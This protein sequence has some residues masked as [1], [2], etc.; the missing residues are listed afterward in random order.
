M[1]W[2]AGCASLLAVLLLA[3]G[4]A[5]VAQTDPLAGL[6][7]PE[8]AQH[9]AQLLA[10]TE[11]AFPGLRFVGRVEQA[12]WSDLAGQYSWEQYIREVRSGRGRGG[13]WGQSWWSTR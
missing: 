4:C 12:D 13:W 8:R 5:C 6:S 2:R 11:Q 1:G 7:E 10:R 3:P 9:E